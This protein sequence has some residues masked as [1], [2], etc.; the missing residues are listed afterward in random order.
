MRII[1]KPYLVIILI[2]MYNKRDI[3]INFR[4]VYRAFVRIKG[5]AIGC[6]YQG[7]SS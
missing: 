3:Y 4:V 6:N 5:K 1:I 7:R 2:C